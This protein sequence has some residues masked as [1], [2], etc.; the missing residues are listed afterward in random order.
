MNFI[1]GWPWSLKTHYCACLGV[2]ILI[3]HSRAILLDWRVLPFEILALSVCQSVT[4]SWS[5]WLVALFAIGSW[6]D[7]SIDLIF[8]LHYLVCIWL[9]SLKILFF[10]LLICFL[11]EKL[12]NTLHLLLTRYKVFGKPTFLFVSKWSPVHL[13]V[14][15]LYLLLFIFTHVRIQEWV[16]ENQRLYPGIAAPRIL[17]VASRVLNVLVNVHTI[18]DCAYV[19]VRVD[20]KRLVKILSFL[21]CILR[22]LHQG[23]L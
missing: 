19:T 3:G 12:V 15:F 13:H 1:L 14:T 22:F 11:V 20:F 17:R 7:W 4:N 5:G 9:L 10:T 2:L 16:I 6:F 18:L 8:S 23:S 21:L